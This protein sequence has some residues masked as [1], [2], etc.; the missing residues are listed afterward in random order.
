MPRNPSRHRDAARQHVAP[1]SFERGDRRGVG[2]DGGTNINIGT[3]TGKTLTVNASAGVL[4]AN[5]NRVFTVTGFNT[6]NSDVLTINGD[7]AGDNVVLNFKSVPGFNG[8]ANFNN[9]VKLVGLT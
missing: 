8:S 2:R 1:D 5:H 4:D 9:Q 6:T 3:G 7:A